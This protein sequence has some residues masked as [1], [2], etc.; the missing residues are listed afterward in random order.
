MRVCDPRTPA[1]AAGV[2]P[3]AFFNVRGLPTPLILPRLRGRGDRSKSG[4]RGEFTENNVSLK[5]SLSERKGLLGGRSRTAH[6]AFITR[7]PSTMLRMV[8]LPR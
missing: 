6:D 5:A 8:P 1:S 2:T 7:A 4:G 3:R